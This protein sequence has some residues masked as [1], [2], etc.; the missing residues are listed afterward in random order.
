MPVVAAAA[1]AP[2]PT[3]TRAGG[4]AARQQK[5]KKKV[6]IYGASRRD[7]KSSLVPTLLDVLFKDKCPEKGRKCPN[8][9][10]TFVVNRL[11]HLDDSNVIHRA[12][13]LR[14]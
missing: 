7:P 9:G 3:P 6:M 5:E 13:A 1:A 10:L 12:R 11:R 2:V 8:F 14:N 4:G